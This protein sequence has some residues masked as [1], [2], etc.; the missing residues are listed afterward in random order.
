MRISDWSSDVCSSDLRVAF[1]QRAKQEGLI[2][3]AQPPFG[4]DERRH[5]PGLTER[6]ARGA[7]EMTDDFGD[8]IEPFERREAPDEIVFRLTRARHLRAQLQRDRKRTRLN[9]RH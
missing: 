2:G 8:E 7:I 1:A 3:D 6:A 9:S 4:A 5:H